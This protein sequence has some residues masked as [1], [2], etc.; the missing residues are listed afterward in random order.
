MS[1]KS[2]VL[3][4]LT[5]LLCVLLTSV[6]LHVLFLCRCIMIFILSGLHVMFFFSEQ[7]RLRLWF[8]LSFLRVWGRCS[9]IVEPSTATLRCWIIWHL[10][11]SNVEF[12]CVFSHLVN[13]LIC[14]VQM[15]SYNL[16]IFT[17]KFLTLARRSSGL[18]SFCH[19]K[20]NMKFLDTS[21][22]LSSPWVYFQS[23][24]LNSGSS[25]P[26]WLFTQACNIFCS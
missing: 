8:C 18:L 4:G 7:Y 12:G 15:I 11:F 19:L 25:N 6:L 24:Q 13:Y 14:M 21:T 5:H 17:L 23:S 10:V 26:S 3:R 2:R 22:L 20:T 9:I 1:R 16:F